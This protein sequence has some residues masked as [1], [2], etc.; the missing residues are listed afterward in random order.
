MTEG[1][2]RERHKEL[3]KN[4]DIKEQRNIGCEDFGLAEYRREIH[5]DTRRT[6]RHDVHR[7]ILCRGPERGKEALSARVRRKFHGPR[8]NVASRN[9]CK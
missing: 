3:A 1:N 4:Y 2:H 7:H 9:V 8:T 5:G 6:G